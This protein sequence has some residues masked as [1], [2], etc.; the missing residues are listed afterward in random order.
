MLRPM[1]KELVAE[2]WQANYDLTRDSK[3]TI[4]PMAKEEAPGKRA[5]Q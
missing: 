1:A 3:P 4:R 2:Q 5:G